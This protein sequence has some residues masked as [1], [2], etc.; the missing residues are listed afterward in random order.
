M[1]IAELT[2]GSQTFIPGSEN[3]PSQKF[4]ELLETGILA[5]E[6]HPF[7]PMDLAFHD[8]GQKLLA[9][10]RLLHP[11][12]KLAR[13]YGLSA[14]LLTMSQVW[15]CADAPGH[16]VAAKGAPEAVA[17]LCRLDEAA[18][19][20]LRSNVDSMA[21][22]G[23]RVLAVA[24]AKYSDSALPASQREFAFE[25]LGLVGLAD[26]L[27][28]NV[29]DAIR[30]CHEAGIRV[31]MITGDYPTTAGAIARLAGI[32]LSGRG[33]HRPGTRRDERCGP[34]RAHQDRTGLRAHHAG[35]EAQ[36][37]QRVQECR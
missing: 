13:Q 6:R 18:L 21:A 17:E 19:A 25:L 16:T 29:P 14:D 20:E 36:A 22:R 15:K 32:D 1:S 37:R 30:E 3:A 35:A 5:S 11:E 33:A 24:R 10:T 28:A 7:D 4:L 2:I 34:G 23:M 8:L 27:R 31:A 9:D 26:P 12:W